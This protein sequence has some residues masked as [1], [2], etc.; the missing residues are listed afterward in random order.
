MTGSWRLRVR[1]ECGDVAAFDSAF[2]AVSALVRRDP[3][4][5]G[6]LPPELERRLLSLP[7]PF[8]AEFWIAERDGRPLGR[9]GANVSPVHRN[10]GFVGFYEVD[11]EAPDAPAVASAMLAAAL[12]WIGGQTR[13]TAYGPLT[14]NTW[15]PYRFRIDH[16]PERFAW[17][18]GQ[19]PEYVEQF[20]AAGF[21]TDMGYRS[22]AVAGL[23]A[24]VDST[25]ADARKAAA[26]GYSIRGVDR[27]GFLSAELHALTL[28]AFTDAY[29]IEPIPLAVFEQLN[30]PIAE[31]YGF[32]HARLAVD[33]AGK[34][35]GYFFAFEDRSGERPYLVWKTIALRRDARG[36]GLSNA[37]MHEVAKGALAKGLRHAIAALFR[38]GVQS[39]SY[40]RKCPLLWR[41]EYALFRK[42]L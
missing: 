5:V 35:A 30:L 41:H 34:L 7:R 12:A 8:P 38:D 33:G 42:D 19:P 22:E 2:A 39:A 21:A 15:L 28:E 1:G 27:A 4:R 10:A 24:F 14:F 18:P 9:I 29:L 16:D 13:A 37:L 40:S 11:L 25:A 17:E 26:L 31:R 3:Y 20:R 6:I 23:D 36:V 32:E